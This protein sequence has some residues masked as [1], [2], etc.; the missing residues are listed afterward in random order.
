MIQVSKSDIKKALDT[1]EVSQ[2]GPNELL[3]FVLLSMR[4]YVIR[5][6]FRAE[7][8]FIKETGK[9]MAQDVRKHYGHLP[10]SEVRL[11]LE[12]GAS[13]VFGEPKHISVSTF[14]RCISEYLNLNERKTAK[15]EHAKEKGLLQLTEK[16][17]WTEGERIDAMRG[18]YRENL[19]RVRN[20]T[21]VKDLGGLLF[22][23]MAALGFVEICHEDEAEMV[24]DLKAKLKANSMDTY[25]RDLLKRHRAG[26]KCLIPYVQEKVLRKY[27]E[28]EIEARKIKQAS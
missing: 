28:M 18:R 4:E 10:V 1:L 19:E 23:H 2:T 26:E 5:T 12:Y 17:P 3:A 24:E 6:G 21:L 14:F 7:E 8:E 11:A 25:T 13:G 9:I 15:E 22:D 27:F 20:G 16:A